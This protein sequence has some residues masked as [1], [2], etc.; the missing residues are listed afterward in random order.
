MRKMKTKY[1]KEGAGCLRL[2]R[3]REAVV[4]A[5]FFVEHVCSLFLRGLQMLFC[6]LFFHSNASQIALFTFS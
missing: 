4:P 2:E 3:Q 6:V 1:F 5:P